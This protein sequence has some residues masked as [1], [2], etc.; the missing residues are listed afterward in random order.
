VRALRDLAYNND[1][2]KISIAEAGTIPPLVA[3]LQNGTGDAKKYDV[4]ALRALAYN[5][6][7]NQVSIAK[8]GAIPPLVALLENGTGENAAATLRVL[9]YS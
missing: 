8:A 4:R 3:L 5:N 9:S 7:K 6:D 1:N 2:N